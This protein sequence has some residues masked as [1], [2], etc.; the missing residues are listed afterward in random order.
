VQFNSSKQGAVNG[1]HDLCWRHRAAILGRKLAYRAAKKFTRT[2]RLELHQLD[3]VLVVLS[4]RQIRFR[5]L[6]PHEI[7]LWQENAPS[8]K[9]LPHIPN[10]VR[11]LQRKSQIDRIFPATRVAITK[12][13]NADQPNRTGDPVTIDTKLF[14]GGISRNAQIHFYSSDDF[15]EHVG[16][17][18]IFV[19]QLPHIAGEQRLVRRAGAKELAPSRQSHLLLDDA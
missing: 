2:R 13:L 10:Y 14:K 19:H 1:T 9:I 8:L 16:W 7:F 15:L 4:F 18:R 5:V 6:E 12:Y 3:E 17:K 11:H